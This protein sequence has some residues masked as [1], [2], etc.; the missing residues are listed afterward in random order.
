[1]KKDISIISEKVSH[2]KHREYLI[3]NDVKE[4]NR[5]EMNRILKKYEKLFAAC[6]ARFYLRTSLNTKHEGEENNVLG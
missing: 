4:N 5:D 1:M 2:I 3:I 6:N